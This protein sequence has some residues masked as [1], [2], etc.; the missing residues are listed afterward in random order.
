[1]T[2][3]AR[4][5]V[6]AV[7]AVV[8]LVAADAGDATTAPLAFTVVASP[9]I[10]AVIGAARTTPILSGH[11][12]AYAGLASLALG[13]ALGIGWSLWGNDPLG[14][15]FLGGIHGLIAGA[16][17]SGLYSTTKNA[18]GALSRRP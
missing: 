11:R 14:G 12:H 1:M 8:F 3:R 16:T 7:L 5:L 9:V 10:V 18:G 6:A 15:P 4:A 2:A 13:A 17:A